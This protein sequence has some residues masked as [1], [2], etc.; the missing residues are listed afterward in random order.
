MRKYF[1]IWKQ[2]T[3]C[4]VSSYLSNRLD[5]FCYFLGK[6]VRFGFFLLLIISIFRFTNELAGYSKYEVILFFLTFNLVDV[7]AQAFFRGIYLFRE[8]IRKGNFDYI[9]TKP[10][11][12]LFYSLT[13][14]T[15]ILDIIFL[16]P[17]I[18]LII[19][20][21]FKLKIVLSILNISAYIFFVVLG[22]LIIVGIHIVSACIT[23]WTV[24]GENFIWVYR[25]A[26]TVGRFPPE[27]L[28]S[29][30][31]FIFTFVMPVI[32]IVAF[33][34]KAFLG[35]LSLSWMLIALFY[36]FIFF[37]GSLWLWRISLKKYSSASS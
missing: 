5:S 9:L 34:V 4:A 1:K 7:L 2:L 11:N 26:M 31:Q 20:T 3:N 10:V 19:Y 36:T 37:M 17:I 12:P 24:E 32:I 18:I 22:V 33:P 29:F 23:I 8:D 30:M 21:A 14:L 35:I 27:I 6:L 13:R 25:E 15:D 28:S 16:L